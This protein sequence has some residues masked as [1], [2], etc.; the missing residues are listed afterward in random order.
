MLGFVF[1]SVFK[2]G[3]KSTNLKSQPKWKELSV[4]RPK[5]ILLQDLNKNEV[6]YYTMYFLSFS[7]VYLLCRSFLGFEKKQHKFANFPY[8]INNLLEDKVELYLTRLQSRKS[9]D[10]PL[11]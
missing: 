1:S 6:N 10:I 9:N 7:V 8:V 3:I 2:S 4:L 5:S 11:W